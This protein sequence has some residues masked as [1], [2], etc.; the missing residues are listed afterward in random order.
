MKIGIGADIHLHSFSQF[1]VPWSGSLTSRAEVCLGTLERAYDV[2][3]EKQCEAVILAGDV[4]HVSNPSA[5]LLRRAGDI[6][7][8]LATWAVLGNHDMET[9]ALFDNACAPLG[10]SDQI[11]VV[12][13]TSSLQGITLVPFQNGDPMKWLPQALDDARQVAPDSKVLVLH[14]GLSTDRTPGYM[15]HCQGAIKAREL[16]ALCKKRGYDRVF[17]G[18]W[19]NPDKWAPKGSGFEA[20]QI[21]TLI[22]ASFSD[23]Y[24]NVGR[25][26]IYDTE[27]RETEFVVIPGPRFIKIDAVE[28]DLHAAKAEIAHATHLFIQVT[29]TPE[30]FKHKRDE[31]LTTL[32]VLGHG[33][34]IANLKFVPKYRVVAARA[35]AEAACDA[36][37]NADSLQAAIQTWLSGRVSDMPMRT[38]VES[39]V[40][41]FIRKAG[42]V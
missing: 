23:A 25:V 41:G 5:Q 31:A 6:L 3:R 11:R 9:F 8:S 27:T 34:K 20:H 1:A 26:A 39:R 10:L 33:D 14:M 21:S 24:K 7:A 2:F 12:E 38:A 22:P 40:D 28:K 17:M 15:A 29:C 19:H 36:A 37:K 32:C 30:D 13:A 42:G 4:F 16:H 35:L 18:D